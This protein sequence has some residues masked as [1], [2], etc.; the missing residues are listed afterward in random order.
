MEVYGLTGGIGSGKSTVAS[1]LE[2]YG[3]P[4]VSADEL[5]RMVVAPGSPG[6]AD[7]VE[8]FGPEVLDERGELDR[9]KM[10]KIVFATPERRRQLEA[11]LHPRIRERYEQVLDALEKAGHPVMVYEV[12]L[13]FEKKLDQQDEMK[14]V[15]LVAATADTRIA[16]VKDR[17][18]LTTDDVLARMRTQMP[19]EEK[20][21]RADYIVHNDGDLDDLRREVEYLLSR[22]LRIPPRA[23]QRVRAGEDP[24]EV[25][26]VLDAELEVVEELEDEIEAE[27]DEVEVDSDSAEE[28]GSE[29]AN[30]SQAAAQPDHL[31]LSITS[32]HAPGSAPVDPA[33][34]GSAPQLEVELQPTTPIPAAAPHRSGSAWIP[35]TPPAA[36]PVPA[37]PSSSGPIP[38]AAPAPT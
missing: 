5:S 34:A 4:V 27:I 10:G 13:L 38:A 6:L 9:K 30:P 36:V 25:V 35:A 19:E 20:R 37:A 3:I 23:D 26:E 16:R 14:A 18:A 21:E 15:I 1:M 29:P 32:E 17:D 22:F 31:E 33:P 24:L 28:V 8:A 11:I 7:V 2:E 12:P